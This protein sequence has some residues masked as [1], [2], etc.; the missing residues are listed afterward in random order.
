M[1]SLL[2]VHN[3]YIAKEDCKGKYCNQ[4]GFRRI[5]AYVKSVEVSRNLKIHLELEGNGTVRFSFETS[6]NKRQAQEDI[7]GEICSV[8]LVATPGSSNWTGHIT[9]T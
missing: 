9:G 1:L 3:L 7:Q 2:K 5:E 4:S 8:S 6:E